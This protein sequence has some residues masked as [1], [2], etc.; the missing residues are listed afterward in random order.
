MCDNDKDVN[1][2]LLHSHQTALTGESLLVS[3]YTAATS[4][5]Q[6]RKTATHCTVGS[7]GSK[8]HKVCEKNDFEIVKRGGWWVVGGGGG[9]RSRD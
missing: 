9:G 4:A 8:W 5:T 6:R 2:Y 1:P 7:M 3:F